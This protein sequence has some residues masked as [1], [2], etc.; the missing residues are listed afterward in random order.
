MK[1][2]KLNWVILI[3]RTDLLLNFLLPC[4][5]KMKIP[6]PLTTPDPE[7]KKEQESIA[8]ERY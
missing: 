7:K 1:H 4:Q 5:R 8:G 6:S 2:F 3:T